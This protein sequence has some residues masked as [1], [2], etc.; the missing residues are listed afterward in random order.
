MKMENVL[1]APRD[2]FIDK[3]NLTVG[4]AVDK[5]AILVTYEMK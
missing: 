4:E 3:V 2:G 1:R 5:G